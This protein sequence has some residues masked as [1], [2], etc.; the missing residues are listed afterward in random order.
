M[1]KRV[2]GQV[3]AVGVAVAGLGWL[4]RLAWPFDWRYTPFWSLQLF[5]TALAIIAVAT[6][7]VALS[8]ARLLRAVLLMWATC[9]VAMG[10]LLVVPTLG[11]EATEHPVLT[12]VVALLW[13][14]IGF[15]IWA[16]TA[17]VLTQ[18]MLLPARIREHARA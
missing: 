4:L 2:T 17:A 16:L 1:T 3:F 18:V 10:A 14:S 5:F 7:V 11:G 15:A 8:S 6:L 13:G 9:V 12:L